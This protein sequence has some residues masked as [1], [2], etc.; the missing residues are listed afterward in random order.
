VLDGSLDGK[1]A[2]TLVEKQRVMDAALD[3]KVEEKPALP[4]IPKDWAKQIVADAVASA[5]SVPVAAAAPV[6]TPTQV[7]AV[8]QALRVVAGYDSDRA[9]ELNG[10][11]FSKLDTEFGCSLAAQSSLSP[12][13][14]V[15]GRKMVT[16]YKRQYSPD[17]FDAMWIK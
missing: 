15:A 16:R 1:M 14:A 6:L 12:R 17:L 11:G 10:V 2:K 4:A 7:A 8:H 9:R 5:A 3:A 13:Q